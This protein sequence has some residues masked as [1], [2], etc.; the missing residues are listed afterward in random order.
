[1]GCG[2]EGRVRILILSQIGQPLDHV[3]PQD[4]CVPGNTRLRKS[5]L[6]EEDIMIRAE[7]R[8]EQ[9]GGVQVE[10][11]LRVKDASAWEYVP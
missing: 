6:R 5:Q 3:S 8:L 9:I 10:L 7:R 2:Y 4:R 11:Q 1:M